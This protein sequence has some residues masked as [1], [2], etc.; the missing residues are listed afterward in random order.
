MTAPERPR[1]AK[2]PENGAWNRRGMRSD[3]AEG[4]GTSM[5]MTRSAVHPERPPTPTS[6]ST[7]T[8]TSTSTSTPTPTSTPT[9]DTRRSTRHFR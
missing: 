3:T 5:L 6:T 8:P 9:Y 7:S 4:G 2:G 1:P